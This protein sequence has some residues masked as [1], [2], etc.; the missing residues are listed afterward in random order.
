MVLWWFL[1]GQGVFYL[2][3]W[4]ESE[5]LPFFCQKWWWWRWWFKN[6]AIFGINSLNFWGV[7]GSTLQLVVACLLYIWDYI[8]V[9]QK[10]PWKKD[11]DFCK[12]FYSIL[13]DSCW[14]HRFCWKLKFFDGVLQGSRLSRWDEKSSGIVP[15]ISNPPFIAAMGIRPFR[16][17]T[18][19][20]TGDHH[21]YEPRIQVLGA[22]PPNIPEAAPFELSY[23][24][25][26]DVTRPKCWGQCLA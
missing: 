21:G 26:R 22:H 16:R 8:T 12:A 4:E 11:P 9:L 17:G 6:M 7:P 15:W 24:A 5:N 1:G 14:T 10:E 25:W 18:T 3:F 23:W 20:G 2:R 19:P 13:C